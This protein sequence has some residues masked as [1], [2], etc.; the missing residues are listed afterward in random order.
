MAY[1]LALRVTFF[2]S[3]RAYDPFLVV[4]IMSTFSMFFHKPNRT[5]NAIKHFLTI[6]LGSFS[7]LTLLCVMQ[8]LSMNILTLLC[9]MQELSMNVPDIQHIDSTMCHAGVEYEHIDSTM[10]HAGVEYERP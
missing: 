10:C 2:N 4:Q 5:E 9:V 7:I 3:D 6:L 1:I 8:E